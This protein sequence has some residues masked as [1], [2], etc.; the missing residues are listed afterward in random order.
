MDKLGHVMTIMNQKMLVVSQDFPSITRLLL[1]ITQ[2]LKIAIIAYL[3]LPYR[4][5][6][7]G[8]ASGWIPTTI[9]PRPN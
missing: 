6:P 2:Y 4:L 3:A 1:G 9:E 7:C 8:I 5:W